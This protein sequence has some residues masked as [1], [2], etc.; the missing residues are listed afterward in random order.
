MVQHGKKTINPNKICSFTSKLCTFKQFQKT[1]ETVQ[2]CVK[3]QE[4][5]IKIHKTHFYPSFW[6]CA[7]FFWVWTNF[8]LFFSN[9]LTF[10]FS[11]LTFIKFTY[12][13]NFYFFVPT[14]TEF[15]AVNHKFFSTSFCLLSTSIKIAKNW[16]L[17]NSNKV[18]RPWTLEIISDEMAL[19]LC[20]YE[21]WYY[22]PH[23]WSNALHWPDNILILF[24]TCLFPGTGNVYKTKEECLK[25]C[26]P[27]MVKPK[28]RR[29]SLYSPFLTILM[30]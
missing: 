25:T 13:Y 16:L 21:F 15:M 30:T 9:L 12:F 23:E 11:I 28:R 20:N 22:K 2:I 6:V 19:L 4:N 18:S 14:F 8:T 10:S 1:W 7:E 29:W 5:L 24:K 27:L 17:W 26:S 3:S